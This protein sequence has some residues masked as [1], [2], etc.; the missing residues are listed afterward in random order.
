MA[1]SAADVETRRP[2]G[3]GGRLTAVAV[4]GALLTGGLTGVFPTLRSTPVAAAAQAP[5]SCPAAVALQNGGFEQPVLPANSNAQ[6]D[7]SQVPGWLTTATD[8][9]IELWRTPFRNVPPGSGSQ[10]AELNATQASTLYQDVA[11]TPGQV[12]RW[13]LQHRGREGQDTMALYIAAPTVRASTTN[14]QALITDSNTAWGTYSGVYTVPAGQTLTRFSFQAVSSSGPN[15]SVGNLLDSISFGT[16]PCLVTTTTVSLPPG[17]STAQ[18][19]DV[20][21]YT[22]TTANNGGN[23]AREVVMTDDLPAGVA[24]VPGSIVAVTGTAA[25]T[26]TDAAGDDQAEY[27][28]STGTGNG[29]VRVRVGRS[30][31]S[32]TGGIV[33][34][35]DARS[36]S[37]QVRV[38]PTLSG[39]TLRNDARVTYRDDLSVSTPTSTSNEVATPVGVAADLRATLTQDTAPLVAGRPATWTATLTNRGPGTEPAPVLTTTVPAALSG[40]TATPVGGGSC[41]VGG[42]TVTCTGPALATGAGRS[43]TIT[44]T[45]PADATPGAQY[46]ALASVRGDAHDQGPT[47]N[48][49]TVSGPVT[50]LADV[51]VTLASD[52]ATGVAG[53]IV[54]YTAVVTNDGPST[55]RGVRLVDPLPASSAFQ[56]AAVAGGTCTIASGSNTVTCTLPD[57]APGTALPVVVT[58]RLAADGDG[59]IDNAVSV[60]AATPDRDADDLTASVRGSGTQRADLSVALQLDDT[61]LLPGE[62]LG[63]TVTVRNDGISDAT[64]VSVRSTLPPGVQ[65]VSTNTAGCVPGNCSLPVVAAGGNVVI[66]GTAEVADDAP[67]GTVL[68]S[69][70]VVSAV[71]DVDTDDQSATVSATI[72]LSAD[73]AVT[74]ELSDPADP[75]NADPV[76]VAGSEVH[77][78]ATVTNNGPTRASGVQLRLATLAGQPVPRV[79]PS[80][81]GCAY[82]G[83]TTPEGLAVDGG[84]VVCWLD[85]LATGARWT[86]TSDGVLP[87]TYTGTTFSR[88]RTVSST[89][90]DPV[91]GND[92]ASDSVAV[93]RRADLRVVKT[94]STPSVVQT[95]VVRFRVTVTNA[96]PSH[97]RDVVVREQPQ[98]GVVVTGTSPSAGSFGDAAGVWRIPHLAAGRSATLDVTGTAESPDD[99]ENRAAATGSDAVDPQPANDVGAVT[100]D[101][102]PAVRTLTITAQAAVAPAV[103][104]G[105]ARVGDAVD[106]SYVVRNEGNVQISGLR[107]EESLVSGAVACPRDALA[108]GEQMTCTSGGT[109]RVTQA[110]VDAGTP[111][112][113]RATAVGR[114][115]DSTTDLVFGPATTAVPM[116]AGAPALGLT[117]VANWDDA[118]RDDALDA[119]ETVTW[120]A[121]VVNSGDLTVRGLTVSAPGT[122]AF[123]CSDP[124][125]APGAWTSC[126]TAATPLTAAD[127][128]AGRR[129]TT[130]TATATEARAGGEVRSATSTTAVPAVVAPALRMTLGGVVSP[131]TRQDAAALGDRVAWRYTVTNTGNVELTGVAVDDPD[132]GHATCAATVLQP[133]QTT[134]CTS[135]ATHVV[136]EADVLAG[137]LTGRATATGA[138]VTGGGPVRAPQDQTVVRTAGALRSLQLTAAATTSGNGPVR[139]GDTIDYGYTVTNDGNVTMRLVQVADELVGPARCR[140]DVLAPGETTDCSGGGSHRVTQVEFDA[141]RPITDLA[142]V[143]GIPAGAATPLTFGPASAPVALAA[144][145]PVL[146]VLGVA[147]WTDT[148]VTGALEA[149][150]TIDWW[151][152]VTNPGDVT[153]T[154]ITVT[155]TRGDVLTCPVPA[156]GPGEQM[157]CTSPRYTVTA[158]DAASSPIAARFEV[159]GDAPRGLPRVTGRQDVAVPGE[160]EPALLLTVGQAVAGSP[161]PDV[162]DRVRRLFTVSNAGNVPVDTLAVTSDD[163]DAVT[164]EVTRLAPGTSTVCRAATVRTVTEADVRTGKLAAAGTASAQ[165]VVSRAAV[166]DTATQT[167]FLAPLVR[168]LQVTATALPPTTDPLAVGD[169]VTYRYAVRNVGNTTMTALA[170]LDSA[171]GTATCDAA[172]LA[173]GAETTCTGASTYTVTQA[174]F[175]AGLPVGLTAQVAGLPAGDPAPLTYGPAAAPLPLRT[176]TPVLAAE[177]SADWADDGNGALDAGESI[178]WTV[179]VRN[180]GDV[181]VHDLAVDDPLVHVECPQTSVAPGQQVD[182]AADAYRATAADALAGERTNTAVARGTDPRTGTPVVSNTALAS[183]AGTP[184]APPAL[185]I[186]VA[187]VVSPAQ[188]QL[189]AEWGDGVRWRYTVTNSGGVPIATPGVLDDADGPVACP[190]TTLAPG[191][192]VVCD[193]LL[194][195]PVTEADVLAAAVRTRALAVG[196]TVD[197]AAPADTTVR[198]AA[199]SP[200]RSTPADGV[201]ATA[202]GRPALSLTSWLENTTSRDRDE[203]PQQDDLVHLF[204]RVANTGNLTLT[205]VAVDDPSSG[206]VVCPQPALGPGEVMEC[207]TDEP[208]RVDAADVAAGRLLSDARATGTPPAAAGTAPTSAPATLSVPVAASAG[209]PGGGDPGD[210]GGAPVPVTGPGAG[211][212]DPGDPDEDGGPGAGGGVPGAP[213]TTGAPADEDAPAGGTPAAAGSGGP[214]GVPPAALASTGTDAG[215]PLVL[216]VVSVLLGSLLLVLARRRVVGRRW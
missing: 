80:A 127:V 110:D 93:V 158:A 132:A 216:G 86:V 21:T 125:L 24:Y 184:L 94:T 193:G 164:C 194:T 53:G 7:Q 118:D 27:D 173:P 189:A 37:Y 177:K 199:V 9:L 148:G 17:R 207:R 171:G 133:G 157:R 161:T 31:T 65:I 122:P 54:R 15:A 183:A 156:L 209:G 124:V 10:F 95:G 208:R 100:V 137:G 168:A 138:P 81:G 44:G 213:P 130:A 40:V 140:Q 92:T 11:T 151:A 121:V 201:V 45:V 128:S 39:Q 18:V 126:A 178:A 145:T 64:N 103:D 41:T 212:G 155:S 22:V 187:G 98:P 144:A 107:V 176:S 101:V 202:A 20:L 181:T 50:A 77:G 108:P 48:T 134:V 60:A 123:T 68:A 97:A 113:S 195:H 89:S 52:P 71:P 59:H 19:G 111:V 55:A 210:G 3:L 51:S 62:T 191:Q 175:D 73:L 196:V 154:G 203:A 74:L 30:A 105:G 13:E 150:E 85:Q 152:L 147:D 5:V 206:T 38:L 153:L 1:S 188:R 34:A 14:R 160:E 43:V 90:A 185:T 109:Y 204:Y 119:G 72:R 139:A 87:A 182:C 170:V 190:P 75:G 2:R 42:T 91:S 61:D 82:Q 25:T 70:T 197:P 120:T 114:A 159:G 26:R 141:G 112:T 32:T 129:T 106:L 76:L 102:L 58:V 172:S 135:D 205:G 143:S 99:V 23:P 84:V 162:G 179:V 57:L 33:D 35:G 116:A 117:L 146:R 192:V 8:R 78:L 215:P 166:S 167:L 46:T 142:Q 211:V 29:T 104:Q 200:V 67:E 4:A 174:D 198:L 63:F 115:P 28:T 214:P 6:L 186:A 180:T 36:F 169:R 16:Q 149:G 47:D 69:A 12:L 83:T 131:S 66:T 56:S 165:A 49:A 88:T 136:T 163:G 79:V 96:G